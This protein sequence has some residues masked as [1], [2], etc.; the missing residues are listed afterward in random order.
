MKS[1]AI[2]R[3][4]YASD[5]FA[6]RNPRER[7]IIAVAAILLV[8][9]LFLS[10]VW[11]PLETAHLTALARLQRQDSLIAVMRSDGVR[12]RTLGAAGPALS[13]VAPET[14]ITEEATTRQLTIQRF[15]REG[16]RLSVTIDNCSFPD[17]IAWL[18]RLETVHGLKLAD[19][20]LTRRPAPGIVSAQVTLEE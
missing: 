16:T 19:L 1:A 2:T 18:N 3:A 5:W 17:L 4:K 9:G 15:D 11:R 6:S 14:A 13:A 7:A 12:L 20:E 10:L 8:I